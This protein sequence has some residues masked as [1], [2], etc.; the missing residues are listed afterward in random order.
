MIV[1]TVTI[2][3]DVDE[4]TFVGRTSDGR[5]VLFAEQAGDNRTDVDPVEVV[6]VYLREG[7]RIP[8]TFVEARERAQEL[9]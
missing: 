9:L 2:N 5:Y 3:Y 6:S 7:G 4:T 8:D 1:R